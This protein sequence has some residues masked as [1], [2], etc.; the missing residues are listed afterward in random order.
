[1]DGAPLAKLYLHMVELTRS[2]DLLG[3]RDVL[4]VQVHGP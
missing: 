4:N 1:M 3:A 2:H